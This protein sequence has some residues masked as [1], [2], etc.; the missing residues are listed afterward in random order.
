MLGALAP[1]GTGGGR[2]AAA[3]AIIELSVRLEPL[4]SLFVILVLLRAVIGHF[5]G[6]VGLR[7]QAE[8]VDSLR[9]CAWSALLHCDWRVLAAMRQSDSASL[10]VT[11][12]DRV[13]NSIHQALAAAATAFI[14]AGIGM[15]ALVISP[16]ITLGL[17][18]GGA[19]VLLAYRRMQS[20]ATTQGEQLNEAYGKVYR[21]IQEGLSALRVIKSF[22]REQSAEERLMAAFGALRRSQAVFVRDFR[23]GQIALQGGGALVLALLVWLA[24]ARWH[25]D[26]ATVLPMVALSARALPLL[27]A[28]QEA[29]QNWAHA[30]PA[31][32]ATR[33]LT[34]EAEAPALARMLL[35]LKLR[36]G[37]A[38]VRLR[39]SIAS[40]L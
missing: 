12:I 30:R 7:A 11:S 34:A 27:G 18:A 38:A 40:I 23:L 5:R 39:R 9:R 20:R 21:Q 33:A 36:C 1:G 4:L 13:G 29:W 22:G 3:L 26:M 25:A 35:S 24:I 32:A 6:L 37:F 2:I 17:I 28:L 31:F 14:L 8:I 10:L 15:A 19:L 16:A